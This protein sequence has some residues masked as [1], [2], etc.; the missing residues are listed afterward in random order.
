MDGCHYCDDLKSR[1][2]SAGIPYNTTYTTSCGFSATPGTILSNGTCM[3][4]PTCNVDCQFAAIQNEHAPPTASPTKAVISTAT[5]AKTATATADPNKPS[6]WASGEL[7]IKW[8]GISGTAAKSYS[9]ATAD[10]TNP[11][12]PEAP[13]GMTIALKELAHKKSIEK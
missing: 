1:L 11:L 6:I 9:D 10:A 2:T 3:G 12:P 7:T 5:T 13:V 4:Y 8:G